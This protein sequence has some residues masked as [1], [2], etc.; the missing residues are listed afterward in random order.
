MTGV[1]VMDRQG[2]KN[3]N[4]IGIV[5]KTLYIIY[6]LAYAA[7]TI[8][9]YF[10]MNQPILTDIHKWLN[11]QK[12]LRSSLFIFGIT[13]LLILPFLGMILRTVRDAISEI[14]MLEEHLFDYEHII[15]KNKSDIERHEQKIKEIEKINTDL[16]EVRTKADKYISSFQFKINETIHI[17][18]SMNRDIN[19]IA[20]AVL[21]PKKCKELEQKI[22]E[23]NRSL[24]QLRD[25]LYK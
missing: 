11:N 25:E 12:I 24:I 19:K 17:R 2:V 15:E 18:N 21:K 3:K 23:Y 13:S 1:R 6:I 22:S 20:K 8:L 16:M 4:K 7:F 9:L 14:D 5:F 10:N